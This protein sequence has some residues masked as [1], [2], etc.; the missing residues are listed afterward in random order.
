MSEE[1]A[2]VPA[3]P[4]Q[5]MIGAVSS[6]PGTLGHVTRPGGCGG[7]PLPVIAMPALLTALLMK[8][9]IWIDMA[10]TCDLMEHGIIGMEMVSV[11]DFSHPAHTLIGVSDK[12]RVRS[13]KQQRAMCC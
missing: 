4:V 8:T 11:L 9:I 6:G 3:T 10:A 2:S 13:D 1:E 7:R 5:L 12:S